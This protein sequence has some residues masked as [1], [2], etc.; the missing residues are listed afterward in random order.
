ML[1]VSETQE[2]LVCGL[3]GVLLD[4]HS[5]EKLCF[6]FSLDKQYRSLLGELSRTQIIFEAESLCAVLAYMLWRDKLAR[7]FICGQ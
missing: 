4:E 7:N 6:S 5:G 2:I 3:G 1:V